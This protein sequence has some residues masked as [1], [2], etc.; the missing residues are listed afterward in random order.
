MIKVGHFNF[1]SK[2]TCVY[3]HVSYFVPSLHINF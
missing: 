1:S 2:L 3:R